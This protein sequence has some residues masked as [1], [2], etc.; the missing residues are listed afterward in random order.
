MDEHKAAKND[1]SKK[2]YE[3]I[4]AS[5]RAVH[6]LCY[7]PRAIL[8]SLLLFLTQVYAKRIAK[9]NRTRK[10]QGL[11]EVAAVG[12]ATVAAVAVPQV[13]ATAAVAATEGG[14]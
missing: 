14:A 13:A 5:V 10:E 2:R 6:H 9:I 8:T 7:Q 11:E 12:C 3:E 4:Q 1:D